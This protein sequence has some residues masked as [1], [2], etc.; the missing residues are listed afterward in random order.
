L[1]SDK[2]FNLPRGYECIFCDSAIPFLGAYTPE[3]LLGHICDCSELFF[4]PS[5]GAGDLI[6]KGTLVED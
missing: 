1:Y 5:V 4:A 2:R 6:R 3:K